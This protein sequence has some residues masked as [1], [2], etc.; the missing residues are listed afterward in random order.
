MASSFKNAHTTVTTSDTDLYVAN[1]VN[2]L[3]AVVHGLFLSNTGDTANVAVTVK[4]FDFTNNNA[5]TILSN[6]PIPANSTLTLDKPLNLEPNDKIIVS[7][8][9]SD[10]E[11]FASVL[12]L[13]P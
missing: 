4:V 13:Y 9:N 5:R 2:Q 12:E 3:S 10:C 1:G 7:A 6:T 11:A 8:T